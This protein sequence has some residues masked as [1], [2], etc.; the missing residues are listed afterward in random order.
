V[1]DDHHP[2]GF[3][4]TRNTSVEV[5]PSELAVT[6]HICIVSPTPR[7]GVHT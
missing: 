4:K 7:T 5:K 1:D 3:T 2:S 6:H